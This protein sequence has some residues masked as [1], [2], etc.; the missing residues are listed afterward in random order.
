MKI[1]A[2]LEAAAAR[3][4]KAPPDPPPGVI[5]T[6]EISNR[7]TDSRFTRSL[8]VTTYRF[9]GSHPDDNPMLRKV[10]GTDESIGIQSLVS[11]TKVI[12]TLL[13]T[14]FSEEIKHAESSGDE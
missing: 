6:M 2:V 9:S 1:R 7:F 11:G 3:T 5:H 8:G 4:D 12:L 13:M 14:Y 10:H